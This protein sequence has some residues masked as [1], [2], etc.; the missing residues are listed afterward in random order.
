MTARLPH[1]LGDLAAVAQWR[2]DTGFTG[3][4]PD[5]QIVVFGSDSPRTEDRPELQ[6]LVVE[7]ADLQIVA[8]AVCASLMGK[9]AASITADEFTEGG[10]LDHEA[11]MRTCEQTRDAMSGL[12]ETQSDLPEMLTELPEAFADCVKA[13][14]DLAQQKVPTLLDGP[15][16]A[17]AALLASQL[18]PEVLPWIRPLQ[19]GTTPV[20]RTTWEHLRLPPVLPF[21]TRLNDGSLAP[22]AAQVLT[23]ASRLS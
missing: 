21:K 3:Q 17:A 1:E 22:L 4:V 13:I 19:A 23:L 9:D 7:G 11:W 14:A 5:P 6:V 16:P 15:G 10:R 18:N 20:E 2:A 8:A 12:R